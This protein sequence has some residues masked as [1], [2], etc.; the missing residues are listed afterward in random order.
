MVPEGGE[1]NALIGDI[2]IELF[3]GRVSTSETKLLLF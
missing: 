3:D 2:L 1:V